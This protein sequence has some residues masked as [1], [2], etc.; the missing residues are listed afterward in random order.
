MSRSTRRS[1]RFFRYRPWTRPPLMIRCPAAGKNK[2]TALLFQRNDAGTVSLIVPRARKKK[3]SVKPDDFT[4]FWCDRRDLN[5]YPYRTRPSNVRVCQFRHDRALL[6]RNDR[7][8]IGFGWRFVKMVFR[9]FS[10]LSARGRFAWP[11][12]P[13]AV[14][15]PPNARPGKRRRG[16]RAWFDRRNSPA[17]WNTAGWRR[18]ATAPRAPFPGRHR[19]IVLR[20][21]NVNARGHIPQVFLFQGV[22]VVLGVPMR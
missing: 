7:Y 13:A 15:P 17:S 14:I 5:P 16:R 18:N 9:F 19:E 3:E 2:A 21:L 1:S 10:N 20:K 11:H 12:A 22:A 6:F 8:Y 4:D